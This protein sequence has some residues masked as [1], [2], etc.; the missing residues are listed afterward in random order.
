ML[1]HS[2]QGLITSQQEGERVKTATTEGKQRRDDKA[3]RGMREG[4]GTAEE[5]EMKMK[6]DRREAER[7]RDGLG[8]KGST[9]ILI[10]MGLPPDVGFQED[11]THKLPNGP[12]DLLSAL[13]AECPSM[14]P[15][16]LSHQQPGIV[17]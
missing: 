11:L 10:C 3:G 17:T 6:L 9:L 14:I 7:L 15:Q 13:Y 2:Q 8:L 16:P 1:K 4:R 5:R 12:E